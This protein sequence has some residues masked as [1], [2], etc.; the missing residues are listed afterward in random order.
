MTPPGGEIDRDGTATLGIIGSA[1]NFNR[2]MYDTVKIH[3]RGKILEIGSGTG[4]ISKYF[5]SDGYDL[6]LSD[7]SDYYCGILN[8]LAGEYPRPPEI[9]LM[10][11]AAPR[12][13][14]AYTRY[15]GK[16]DSIVMLN[17]LEHISDEK[18]ALANCA[19][20]LSDGGSIIVLVPAFQSLYNTFDRTLGHYRRYSRRDLENVLSGCRYKIEYSRYFNAFGILGWFFSGKILGKK[21]IPPGQMKLYN[22]LIV[23]F[24]ILDR[25]VLNRFGL[26]VIAVGKK[27]V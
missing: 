4:N 25:L 7:R 23:F 13:D 3:C 22:S 27:S 2:W 18:T 16:F 14:P 5:L 26:S 6:S 19:K 11:I 24:K 20:F 8:D 1:E 15:F 17:V 10:D 12:L 9:I 21:L